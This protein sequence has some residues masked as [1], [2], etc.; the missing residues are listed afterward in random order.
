MEGDLLGKRA[1]N[2]EVESSETVVCS[3]D[4]VLMVMLEPK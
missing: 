1:L 2:S 3:S 4:L